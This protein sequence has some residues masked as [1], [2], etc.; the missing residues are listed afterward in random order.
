MAAPLPELKQGPQHKTQRSCES[1]RSSERFTPPLSGSKRRLRGTA[2]FPDTSLCIGAATGA[3]TIA[4]AI[5]LRRPVEFFRHFARN[6]DI[7]S[8]HFDKGQQYL[9]GQ[10]RPTVLRQNLPLL[11]TDALDSPPFCTINCAAIL[12]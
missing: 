8:A 11:E 5:C 12:H 9:F 3:L 6:A 10:R 1:E 4:R 7:A 2:G